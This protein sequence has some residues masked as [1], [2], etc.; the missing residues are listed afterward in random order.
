MEAMDLMGEL[1]NVSQQTNGPPSLAPDHLAYADSTATIVG[2]KPIVSSATAADAEDD[3]D[4]QVLES[5]ETPRPERSETSS[6]RP[7]PVLVAESSSSSSGG[8]LERRC[9]VLRERLSDRVEELRRKAGRLVEVELTLEAVLGGV[10][11]EIRRESPGV[12]E[13]LEKEAGFALPESVSLPPSTVVKLLA[14][15]RGDESPREA[16]ARLLPDY[17]PPEPTSFERRSKQEFRLHYPAP[18]FT[19]TLHDIGLKLVQER[20][21][22][23]FIGLR[24]MPEELKDSEQTAKMSE[25]VKPYLAKLRKEMGHLKPNWRHCGKHCHFVADSAL[26]LSHHRQTLHYR[27]GMMHCAHCDFGGTLNLA[28]MAAHYAN[29][30]NTQLRTEPSAGRFA[31]PL[32]P[33]EFQLKGE[34]AAHLKDCKKIH[35]HQLHRLFAGNQDDESAVNAW[36]WPQPKNLY[37]TGNHA[38]VSVQTIASGPKTL[39]GVP[40]TL[41]PRGLHTTTPRHITPATLQGQTIRP[42]QGRPRGPTRPT[43]PMRM[44]QSHLGE[45]TCE[46]CDFVVADRT[47]LLRHFQAFHRLL[48]QKDSEDMDLGAPLACSRCKE[49]FW[50]YN[51]LERHLLMSHGLVTSDLLQKA[52]QKADDGRCRFCNKQYAF[53]LLQHLVRDHGCKLCSAEVVYSCDVCS[54]SCASHKALQAHLDTKHGARKRLPTANGLPPAA[55]NPRL[56][57]APK[58]KLRY[59][60]TPCALKF[61]QYAEVIE[62]WGQEHLRKV[63]LHTCKIDTCEQCRNGAL[64]GLTID[65]GALSAAAHAPGPSAPAIGALGLQ[66]RAAVSPAPPLKPDLITLED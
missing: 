5:E 64:A 31:C 41:Q 7:P 27:S 6:P 60:C 35:R 15:H 46:I 30:H 29:H 23:D 19:K 8:G 39:I 55:K 22:S 10:L 61:S 47:S 12:V 4:V 21:Y 62:H 1:G 50:T 51:G 17:S 14:Q 63:R 44:Q 36:L 24:N 33:E 16:I 54:F 32:C 57:P 52:Q 42:M 20:A 37:P 26:A 18:A 49:R 13:R 34:L 43:R 25:Q 48:L 59:T 2:N 53:N 45:A 3:D 58:S 9:G 11:T 38:G 66:P 56:V 65:W 40:S 28:V